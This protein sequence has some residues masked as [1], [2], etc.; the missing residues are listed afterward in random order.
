M[1]MLLLKASLRA[2]HIKKKLPMEKAAHSSAASVA[3]FANVQ[4]LYYLAFT[5]KS[6]EI[7]MAAN[8]NQQIR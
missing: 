4:D 7:S 3:P 5:Q 1:L 8:V 6:I 2:V